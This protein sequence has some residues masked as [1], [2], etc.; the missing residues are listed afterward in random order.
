MRVPPPAQNSEEGVDSEKNSH[1]A[2]RASAATRPKPREGHP[3]IPKRILRTL[4]NAPRASAAT[5]GKQRESRRLQTEFAGR[6]T[7][8]CGHPPKTARRFAIHIE[9]S[10]SATARAFQHARKPQRF[11]EA[12]LKFAQGHSQSASTRPKTAAGSRTKLEIPM[13][14]LRERFDTDEI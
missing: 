11:S 12:I 5:R 13:A 9:N 2:P 6:S 3:S 10:H 7:R 14:P 4:K 8:Q 1:D